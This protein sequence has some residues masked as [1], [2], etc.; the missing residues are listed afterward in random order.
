MALALGIVSGGVAL[1]MAASHA[2]SLGALLAY[3]VA[4]SFLF[5][6]LYSL[7]HEAEHR[8]FHLIRG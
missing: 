8:V 5:L 2:R 7:L 6:P 1:Q 4:F 3:G